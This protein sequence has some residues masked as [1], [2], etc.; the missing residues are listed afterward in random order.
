MDGDPR[1][2]WCV[3]AMQVQPRVCA[4]CW[5]APAVAM[6]HW[7]RICCQTSSACGAAHRITR[8]ASRL[9]ACNSDNWTAA[10]LWGDMLTRHA[11]FKAPPGTCSLRAAQLHDEAMCCCS[12]AAAVIAPWPQ[13]APRQG[14][15]KSG[16][17]MIASGWWAAVYVCGT[18][19]MERRSSLGTVFAFSPVSQHSVGHT[20]VTANR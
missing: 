7:N 11:K 20:N 3:A 10:L 2:A 13:R 18:C 5:A 1:L 9:M 4:A 6:S 12:A 15:G 16:S 8:A 19:S 17:S 14:P